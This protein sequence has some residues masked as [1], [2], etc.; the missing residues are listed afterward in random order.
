MLIQVRSKERL[1]RLQFY[2]ILFVQEFSSFSMCAGDFL[3]AYADTKDQFHA[4]V[5]VFFL[6]TGANP[7]EY[8]R[9]I[10]RILKPGGHWLNFGPLTYHHEDS[11]DTL[12]L[13]MPFEEILRLVEKCGFQLDK[14]MGK[15][16]LPPSRY[17]WN[18]DS[19]LQYNY[20]CGFFLARKN[21]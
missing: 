9:L 19:M 18:P 8:I 3:Q 15:G 12:S 16:Q 5:S 2:N 13:E 10:H 6:D 17:T 20:H 21:S 1:V 7:L 11:P 14:V 4:V